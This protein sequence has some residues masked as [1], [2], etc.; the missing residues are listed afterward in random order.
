M[1]LHQL[2]LEYVPQQD[3]LLLRLSTDQQTEIPLWLTRRG[4]QRLWQVLLDVAHAI[5]EVASHGD[6]QVRNALLGFR[7]AAAV[8]AA[9]FD[10]DYAEGGRAYPLGTEP[11]LITR[12]ES[13][14]A[15]RGTR[16]LGL[17]PDEGDGV[18]ISLE[19]KLLHGFMRLLERGVAKADW[20]LELR[21]APTI[22]PVMSG[23]EQPLLN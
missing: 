7:H 19:E 22:V 15:A 8:A 21:I 16:L 23:D 6:P 17:Y 12:I 10:Q 18:R 13:C 20:N 11:L 4:V 9:D 2:K 5:P 3:R 14:G 1:R